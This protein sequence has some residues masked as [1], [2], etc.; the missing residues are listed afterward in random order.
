MT[1]AQSIS[2]SSFHVAAVAYAERAMKLDDNSADAHKWYAI[3]QG[4]RGQFL[5]ISERIQNGFIFKTHIDRAV[6]LNPNDSTLHHLLGRF[7]FE[8][9]KL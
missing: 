1:V 2:Y 7:C 6:E 3:T 8:V 5:K 9:D 4:S